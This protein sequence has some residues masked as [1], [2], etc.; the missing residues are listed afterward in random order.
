MTVETAS[1]ELCPVSLADASHEVAEWVAR[2]AHLSPSLHID[3]AQY[4]NHVQIMFP[5]IAEDL[6]FN[7]D[8]TLMHQGYVT[9]S[10]SYEKYRDLRI[11]GRVPL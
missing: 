8:L 4:R 2:R 7:L 6:F 5:F 9:T 3:I 1:I 10:T 11:E